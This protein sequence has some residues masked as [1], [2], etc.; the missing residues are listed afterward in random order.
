MS[1]FT[2]GTTLGVAS[3]MD[4]V[5]NIENNICKEYLYEPKIHSNLNES[6]DIFFGRRE[7]FG[8]H[9]ADSS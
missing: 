6:L 3:T 2:M 9:P 4:V 5:I 8:L 1:T 7:Y